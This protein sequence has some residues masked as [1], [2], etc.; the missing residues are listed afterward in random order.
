MDIS[1]RSFV[2]NLLGR[3]MLGKLGVLPFSFDGIRALAEIWDGSADSAE[4]AG[5]ELGRR[6]RKSGRPGSV[7]NPCASEDKAADAASRADDENPRNMKENGE[8]LRTRG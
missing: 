8:S 1:R 6:L 2:R 3:E 5:L 7:G 4:E